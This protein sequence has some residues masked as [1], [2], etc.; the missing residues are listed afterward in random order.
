[1]RDALTATKRA[2][3]AWRDADEGRDDIANGMRTLLGELDADDDGDDTLDVVAELLDEHVERL[4]ATS[5]QGHALAHA[6]GHLG[7]AALA[8][9]RLAR[10]TGATG[11]AEAATEDL[12]NAEQIISS[13]VADLDEF[14]NTLELSEKTQADAAAI[15]VTLRRVRTLVESARRKLAS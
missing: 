1:M 11:P 10:L 3:E 4:S 2:V 15:A 8:L 7:T 6:L 5:L 9:N 14:F 13:A 12:A